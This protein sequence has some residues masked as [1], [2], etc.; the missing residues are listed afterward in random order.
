MQVHLNAGPKS[1]FYRIETRGNEA[2]TKYHSKHA[3]E[4]EELRMKDIEQAGT[5]FVIDFRKVIKK[6]AD[7]LSITGYRNSLALPALVKGLGHQLVASYG[8]TAY[9]CVY[10]DREGAVYFLLPPEVR[11]F[12]IT[13]RKLA[14]GSVLFPAKYK[15]KIAGEMKVPPKKEEEPPG[16]SKDKK[17]PAA[18]EGDE[19]EE[20]MDSKTI[21][22]LLPESTPAR[23]G[24]LSL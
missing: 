7:L 24:L 6:E 20:M 2:L 8:R 18:K 16:K 14:D 22:G 17:K 21:S 19:P 1:R 10:E 4:L 5:A 13:G 11:E 23:V 15:I 9:P 12:E 3:A